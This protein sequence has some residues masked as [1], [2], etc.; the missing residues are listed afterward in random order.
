M[1][2]VFCLP[3]SHLLKRRPAALK[4]GRTTSTLIL[5][6]LLLLSA[7]VPI[8]VHPGVLHADV[9]FTKLDQPADADRPRGTGH[10]V[11]FGHGSTFMAV[12]TNAPPYVTTYKRLGDQFLKL[13]GPLGVSDRPLCPCYGV[14]FSPDS[15][16]MA[17]A[18]NNS[19]FVTA[20][21]RSGETYTKLYE[22]VDPPG[23][24]AQSIAFSPDS[25]YMA[26]AHWNTPKVTIYKRS[27]DVLTRLLGADDAKAEGTSSAGCL[28]MSRFVAIESGDITQIR[29][30]CTTFGDVKVA[31]Y[32]DRDGNPG[33]LIGAN[34]TG[35]RVTGG[36]NNID[37]P[38][39]TI[40]AGTPYWIACK[41]SEAC[42]GYAPA[43]DGIIL[44]RPT[45][46]YPAV[47]PRSL[48]DGFTGRRLGHHSLIAGW[49]VAE[50]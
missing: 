16:Y 29:V 31:L 26:V 46:P 15:A 21:K 7:V 6:F 42:I 27:G 37:I 39:T 11:A 43:T 24:F 23:G 9:T 1:K 44:S 25:T 19:P 18:H 4:A 36:W 12:A 13:V 14:A 33:S 50:P 49:G 48:D 45:V 28:L 3:L 2:K 10:G 30:K 22:P 40:A 8:L 17:V 47:F 41:S 35:A 38:S 20:Y 32:T 5:T 34:N